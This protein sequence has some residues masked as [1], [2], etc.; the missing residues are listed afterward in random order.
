MCHMTTAALP[1]PHEIGRRLLSR[2]RELRLDQDVVAERAGV[3][4]P[5]LSR[6]ERGVVPNPKI[7]ELAQ[8]A[9]ALDI[10][11]LALVAPPDDRTL[12]IAETEDV[13][14]AVADL[15]PETASSVLAA[16]RQIL[17]IAQPREAAARS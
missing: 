6:L 9:S 4:R 11:V 1:D 2:R 10:P 15:P 7:Y 14:L 3:S 8:V 5:Y 16:M 12:V 17:A 13:I